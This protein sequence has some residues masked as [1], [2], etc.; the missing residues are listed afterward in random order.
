M[1]FIKQGRNFMISIGFFID[2]AGKLGYLY[3][4]MRDELIYAIRGEGAYLGKQP[5][6]KLSL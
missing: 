4:V 6:G 3:D 2:G 1:N 5:I